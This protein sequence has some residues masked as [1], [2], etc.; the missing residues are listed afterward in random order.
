ML[1][2]LLLRTLIAHW[3]P[4]EV[5]ALVRK[6]FSVS[7]RSDALRLYVKRQ[8]TKLLVALRA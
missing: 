8:G 1:L 7:P 4:F 3:F 2:L 5:R 6:T